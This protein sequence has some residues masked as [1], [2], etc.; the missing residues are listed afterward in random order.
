MPT[1]YMMSPSE[2]FEAK[3]DV[4]HQGITIKASSSS[5]GTVWHLPGGGTVTSAAAALKV[6]VSLARSLPKQLKVAA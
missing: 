5:D 6:A 2:R 3:H 4:H 1:H